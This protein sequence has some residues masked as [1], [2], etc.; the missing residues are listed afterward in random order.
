MIGVIGIEILVVVALTKLIPNFE[1]ISYISWIIYA[2]IV[3]LITV[4]VIVPTNLIIYKK[5]AK[6]L[7]NIAKNNFLKRKVKNI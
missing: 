4:I 6:Q 5:E 3:A 1:I 7:L 2:C